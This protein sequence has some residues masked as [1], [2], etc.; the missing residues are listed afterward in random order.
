MKLLSYK[1][2]VFTVLFFLS[3]CIVRNVAKYAETNICSVHNIKM[4]KYL[5]RTAFGM[6]IRGRDEGF[7]YPKRR[8]RLGCVIPLWPKHRLAIIY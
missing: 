7:P 3:S 1:I 4:K 8:A 5:T 6:P 2:L